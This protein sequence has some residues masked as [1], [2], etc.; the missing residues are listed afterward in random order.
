MAVV[1]VI[2]KAEKKH[3]LSHVGYNTTTSKNADVWA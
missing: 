1:A 3:L 2:P